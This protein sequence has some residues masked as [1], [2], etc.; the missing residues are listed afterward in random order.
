MWYGNSEPKSDRERWLEQD[1]ESAR[2]QLEDSRRQEEEA[3]KARMQEYRER[4]EKERRTAETWPE[5]LQKQEYLFRQ[6]VGY[7]RKFE[8]EYDLEHEYDD[9]FEPGADACAKALEYWKEEAEKVQDE[10]EALEQK[11]T[12]LR[13]GIA[14]KVA[15]RLDEHKDMPDGWYHTA[16]SLREYT[17]DNLG[18]WLCW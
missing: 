4:A 7:Q 12:E 18:D 8:R 2:Q 10:I 11:I 1:L 13:T 5:A 14:H 15:D 6:E 17:E 16:G 9:Y 3:R